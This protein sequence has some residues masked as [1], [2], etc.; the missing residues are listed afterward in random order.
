MNTELKDLLMGADPVSELWMLVNNGE[1]V[2]LEPSLAKLRMPIPK[3]WRHKDN[4]GHT[5]RVL[6][7]AIDREING[8]DLVLRT[9]AV[10]HDIGKPATRKF[11]RPGKVTFD[12]HEIVGQ[13]MSK[14]LLDKHGYSEAEID[15]I[16][17][18]IR[19]HM[20]AYGFNDR[21]WT[22]SGVR[23]LATDAGNL[24][25]LDRLIVVFYSD[26]TTMND[27]K[28]IKIEDGIKKLED[29]LAAVRA[30]DE[31]AAM[32]PA[33]DGFQVME[34]TGL[35]RGRELGTLMKFLNSDEGIALSEDEAME[36]VLRT[37]GKL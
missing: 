16:G 14:N 11:P 32:R 23:R 3:G 21:N 22:D 15:E 7:R 33:L 26:L 20:R 31:R 10:F 8:P 28:R 1:I 37:V 19:L 27:K 30:K 5:V 35:P 9:A 36:W 12:G 34:L 6:E 25:T 24:E 2:D 18:L 4:L 17:T 29:V 13:R